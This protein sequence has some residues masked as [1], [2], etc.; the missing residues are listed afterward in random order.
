MNDEYTIIKKW[1]IKCLACLVMVCTVIVP[2]HAQEAD[3]DPG[4]QEIKD[5]THRSAEIVM[6][7]MTLIGTD[8][9]FGGNTVDTGFD[10]SGLVR[11]VFK[12]A[13]GKILPRTAA[14]MSRLGQ[15]VTQD[16]LKPGDL[17]FYNTRRRR[18]SH[19]GI[20]LGDNKFIHAPSTGKKVR[21]EDMSLAYWKARFNGARRLSDPGQNEL[22][23]APMSDGDAPYQNDNLPPENDDDID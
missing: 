12:E 22:F 9:R 19:V 23:M 10:C 1:A 15:A 18:N 11:Y 21:I 4:M 5:Y 14:G 20:Y 6:T 2:V 7:A 13:W 3:N 8:Y 17:V 16:E